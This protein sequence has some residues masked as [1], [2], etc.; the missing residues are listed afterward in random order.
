M[1]ARIPL[2]SVFRQETFPHSLMS[3][4]SSNDT[5]SSTPR[6]HWLEDFRITVTPEEK[7]NLER[8][9]CQLS[10]AGD[11]SR[12]SEARYRIQEEMAYKWGQYLFA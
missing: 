1:A 2:A 9:V 4:L 12:I 6:S 3:S 11:L 8:I 5:R 7:K 10:G